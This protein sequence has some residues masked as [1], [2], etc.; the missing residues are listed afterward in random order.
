MADATS[1]STAAMSATT[2]LD[3]ET[4]TLAA[5]VEING[6]RMAYILNMAGYA[7]VKELAQLSNVSAIWDIGV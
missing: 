3:L 7:K 2:I 1:S 5:G 4:D 6:A